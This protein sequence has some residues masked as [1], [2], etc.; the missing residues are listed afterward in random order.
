LL[1]L[2]EW[3]SRLDALML[4]DIA[5]QQYPII[6][7]KAGQKLPYLIG[8]GE[9]RFIDEVEMFLRRGRGMI[10]CACEEALECLGLNSGLSKLARRTRRWGPWVSAAPRMTR[11]SLRFGRSSIRWRRATRAPWPSP[12]GFLIFPA[13]VLL[14]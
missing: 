1:Q 10:R 8:A 3:A 13:S 12:R 7:T 9:A 5:D 2:L 4:A 11:D 6:G 14:C